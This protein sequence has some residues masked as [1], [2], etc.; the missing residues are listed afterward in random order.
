MPDA[1]RES[2]VITDQQVRFFKAFGY[3]VFPGLLADC[4]DEIIEAFEEADA[5]VRRRGRVA[6]TYCWQAGLWSSRW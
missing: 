6:R 2:V 1:S 4:I 3:Q 5:Y